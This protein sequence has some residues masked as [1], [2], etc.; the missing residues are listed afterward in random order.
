MQQEFTKPAAGDLDSTIN[1]AHSGT[2]TECD[3]PE[4]NTHKRVWQ[5]PCQMY[6]TDAGL[7]DIHVSKLKQLVNDLGS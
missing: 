5:C 3:K 6:A 4:E 2:Q 7:P 1:E